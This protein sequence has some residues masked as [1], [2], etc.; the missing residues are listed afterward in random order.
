MKLLIVTQAVDRAHP[1]LGFFH[2]WLEEFAK[3]CEK[4]T[5]IAQQTGD[6]ALPKNVTVWSLGK[7]RG[8]KRPVQIRRFWRLCAAAE[9]DV[10][11]VHMTPVWVLL[12]APVW[13]L[14]NI[15]VYLWYEVRRG[16][17]VLT[18]SLHLVRAVFSA[19][20]HGLPS[21]SS[22]QRVVGHGIDTALFCPPAAPR[23]R[24][25]LL[26]V[27]RITRIKRLEA[28]IECLTAL[29]ADYRLRVIGPVVTQEDR[30]YKEELHAL[31]RTHALEGRVTFETTD[32]PGIAAA[33]K[34]ARML[35]HG[36]GGGLDKALLEAMSTG[37][38]IVSC[39]EAGV[40]V[41]PPTCCTTPE[42]MPETV[43]EALQDGHL[44]T[45]ALIAELR[46]IVERDHSLA[47]LIPKMLEEMKV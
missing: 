10:V 25:E 23:E 35:L 12:G 27:G 11:W 38:P 42:R 40:N 6:H 3:H 44:E 36:A 7:E 18:M 24:H 41:L 15:P 21:L 30:V 28:I 13:T 2:R 20:V 4:V 26:A 16:G 39:S 31:M 22:K 5:V 46:S 43:R 32:Q 8:M 29:P 37:C 9:Y 17:W 45:P 47:R 1:V 19:T 33:M 14:K 34:R